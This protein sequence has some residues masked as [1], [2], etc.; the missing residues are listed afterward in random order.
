MPVP[1][2]F[3]LDRLREPSSWRG[4]VWLF[5]AVGIMLSPE[6]AAAVMAAAA[7]TA[8]LVGVFRLCPAITASSSLISS[9]PAALPSRLCTSGTPR[10]MAPS[11]GQTISAESDAL[12]SGQS[13]TRDPGRSDSR[14]DS[15]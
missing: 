10:G 7:A 9:S 13:L 1:L 11:D 15:P 6:Q 3:L 14:D 8:G 4:V 5:S 12:I 2:L